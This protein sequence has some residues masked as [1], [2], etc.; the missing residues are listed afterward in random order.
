MNEL[1]NVH[2][3]KST[4]LV[5]GIIFEEKKAQYFIRIP[6]NIPHEKSY[7]LSQL[8]LNYVHIYNIFLFH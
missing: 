1:N 5:L 6:L 8:L 7:I 4:I 3:V 2:A